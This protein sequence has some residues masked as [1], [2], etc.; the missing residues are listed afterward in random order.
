MDIMMTYHSHAIKNTSAQ[1]E[2]PMITDKIHRQNFIVQLNITIDIALSL[3]SF[4][5]AYNLKKFFLPQQYIGLSDNPSYLILSLLVVIIWFI[6]FQFFNSH[7]SSKKL[8]SLLLNTIK[9]NTCGIFIL[10]MIIYLFKIIDV[11]RLLLGLFFLN[12][13]V[14]ITGRKTISLLT[15]SQAKNSDQNCKILIVGSRQRAAG[16]ISLINSLHDQC[17]IIGCLDIH[18]EYIGTRVKDGV[19]V[20]GSVDEIQQILLNNVVDEV[21]FAMPLHKIENI[22]AYIQLIELMGIRVRIFPDWHIH[23]MLYEPRIAQIY[24]D[25]LN[26]I[27]SMV[28]S[29]TSTRQRDLHIKLICDYLSAGIMFLCLLPILLIISALI[30]ISSKGPVL[31]KQ[32]RVGLNGRKFYVFKF[33][34]MVQD[35]EK[36]LEQIKHMNEMDGPAF[37]IKKDPRIIPFIGTILRKTGID[38]LPQLINVIKGEMSFI[39]PRP[40]LSSEV[41][42]YNIWHRRRLS[43][44]P[45]ITCLWQIQPKRNDLSFDQWMDLDL[46]YIDSWSLKLDI[47]IFFKT[48]KVML[49]GYGR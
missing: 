15:Y 14:L 9:A 25:E 8:S 27:P 37:K 35:A 36:K 30:K 33:R 6:V 19:K 40:P 13:M 22:E 43:M 39:G 44:K 49:L 16:A 7:K 17:S 41:Q 12:N 21:V 47:S 10:I 26:G 5:L 45:G 11:S 4:Y 32:E 1:R 18:S 46:E 24:Y 2:I 34:T 31:F 20:I 23:S 28:L 38:E 48:I 3:L 29:S 42:K